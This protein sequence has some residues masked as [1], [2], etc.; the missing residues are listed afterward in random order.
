MFR[1]TKAATP[2]IVYP[3]PGAPCIP[4]CP[5]EAVR[6]YVQSKVEAINHPGA[7]VLLELID[8]ELAIRKH[9]NS[10]LA[11]LVGFL[12]FVFPLSGQR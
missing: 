5:Q 3:N 12:S 2:V 10:N 6:P 7:S 11:L 1:R 9:D 4:A 8:R